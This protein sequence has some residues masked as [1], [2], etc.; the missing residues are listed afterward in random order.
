MTQVFV[1]VLLPRSGLGVE[2]PPDEA[3]LDVLFELV[4]VLNDSPYGLLGCRREL[5]REVLSPEPA[6]SDSGESDLLPSDF[7]VAFDE[8]GHV[9]FAHEVDD[10][11][12]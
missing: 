2:V 5:G 4:E 6:I 11:A 10:D 7:E 8:V 3:Q 12:I 9:A 1:A